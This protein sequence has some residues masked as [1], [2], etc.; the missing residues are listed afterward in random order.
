MWLVQYS[1]SQLLQINVMIG[2]QV[3]RD[4]QSLATTDAEL[5]EANGAGSSTTRPASL[6]TERDS[7]A[8]ELSDVEKTQARFVM[9]RNI[10]KG[11]KTVIP[12]TGETNDLLDRWLLSD[13]DA[14]E[15]VAAM[16]GSRSRRR[17][18][19]GQV[20]RSPEEDV[21]LGAIQA[22]EIQR[23]TSMWYIIGTSLLCEAVVVGFAAWIFC[24][25]DY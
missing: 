23:H 19:R 21:T 15:I 16:T 22:Q 17:Q 5:R 25:R 3:D 12:K 10:V 11:V 6:T 4:K 24:R 18:A 1:D 9:I 13:S 20:S 14:N 2:M 7:T 8:V